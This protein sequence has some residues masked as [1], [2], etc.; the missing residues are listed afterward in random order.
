M[1]VEKTPSLKKNAFYSI[2][3]RTLNVIFPLITYPYIARIINPEGIGKIEFVSS[4][5]Q[6]FVLIAQIG[7]PIYG[8]K[9]CAKHRH[10]K[11]ILTRTF[12]EIAV[13]NIVAIFVSY[14]ILIIVLA[15]VEQLQNYGQL[16]LVFSF[17]ILMSCSS[18]EW[19]YQ[20]IEDYKY[21]TIRSIFVKVISLILIFI[22]I[23]S[24]DD[25]VLYAVLLV[26]GTSL[27][28]I[29]NLVNLRKHINIFENSG[30]MQFSQHFQAISTLFILSISTSLYV[31]LDKIL[32]GFISGDEYVGFYSIS[33]RIVK[34]VLTV[35]TS[36]SIVML[37]RLSHYESTGKKLV[38]NE[39]IR[40]I[41]DLLL[42]ISIPA[43]FGIILLSKP[44]ILLFA[45]SSY[46]PSI[47]SLQILAPLLIFIS[48]SNFLGIQVLVSLGKEKWT[49]LSTL[50]A[51]F[52]NITINLLL[53]P[54]LNQIGTSIASSITELFVILLQILIV[55]KLITNLINKKNI[56]LYI[57]ASISFFITSLYILSLVDN[58]YISSIIIVF[59]ST[60]IYGTILL[61]FKNYWIKE[62]LS[63]LNKIFK[64]R[65]K[66]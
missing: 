1:Q 41:V 58:L 32:L 33:N 66:I 36:I 50:L 12:Q 56:I 61:L 48:L 45:G 34:L 43:T 49:L 6:Y 59:L 8:I 63:A 20:A 57:F 54:H 25:Y 10:D 28:S 47:L 31:N 14:L 17:T 53:I 60:T 24:S 22:L 44:I 11:K 23:N 38:A 18:V 26:I 46:T 64:I 40:K 16:F 62:F 29:F 65:R 4:F 7:I 27:N 3:L 13:I 21:I 19:F 39:L 2:I 15:S 35:I 42:F 30:R 37:P 55:S 51:S 9:A 5:I 52:L